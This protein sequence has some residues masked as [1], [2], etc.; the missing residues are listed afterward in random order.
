MRKLMGLVVAMWMVCGTA[1]ANAP[2]IGG[3]LDGPLPDPLVE[4]RADEAIRAELAARR[5]LNLQRFRE[6]IARDVFPI[7]TYTPGALNVFVDEE[8]HIC[9]AATIMT[10]D[11]MGELVR[12]QAARDNFIR[13]GDVREGALYDWILHSGF[14]QEEIAMIQEPFMGELIEPD[15]EKDRLRQRYAVIVATLEANESASLDLATA[16]LSAS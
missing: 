2:A 8:G 5:A 3:V 15:A 10:M 16:R 7:N 1:L 14:T 13:L 4:A 12:A 11:G 6:Y 9:A